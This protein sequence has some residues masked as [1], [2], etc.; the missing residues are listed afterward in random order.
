MIYI[1]EYAWFDL[2]DE[3][4]CRELVGVYTSKEQ[5]MEAAAE[6]TKRPAMVWEQ[7]IEFELELGIKSWNTDNFTVYEWE[8]NKQLPFKYGQLDD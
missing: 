3:R 1:L 8:M 4:S 5:A 7:D 6:L 2:G